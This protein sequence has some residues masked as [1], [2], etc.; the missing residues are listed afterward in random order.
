V[1]QT[2]GNTQRFS[3]RITQAQRS[4]H[5]RVQE[6]ERRQTVGDGEAGEIEED[7]DTNNAAAIAGGVSMKDKLAAGKGGLDADV[8]DVDGGRGKVTLVPVCT[9]VPRVEN[10][11]GGFLVLCKNNNTTVITK[12]VDI[13]ALVDHLP[14]FSG[15]ATK[16]GVDLFKVGLFVLAVVADTDDEADGVGGTVDRAVGVLIDSVK[17]MERAIGLLAINVCGGSKSGPDTSLVKGHNG[18]EIVVDLIRGDVLTVLEIVVGNVDAV[19]TLDL[20]K[21]GC[22]RVA[23]SAWEVECKDFCG[24]GSRVCVSPVRIIVL[25]VDKGAALCRVEDGVTILL[26]TLRRV[27]KDGADKGETEID[28]DP[29]TERLGV[30][31]IDGVQD[32]ACVKKVAVIVLTCD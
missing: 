21:V 2:K 4:V 32:V 23:K 16:V 27:A 15:I 25:D 18:A 5:E 13:G 7:E 17:E 30:A 29:K 11:S 6:R 20:G 19:E 3:I 31:R 10:G 28:T 12:L 26:E 22:V 1:P 24:K 8:S 14:R 9:I